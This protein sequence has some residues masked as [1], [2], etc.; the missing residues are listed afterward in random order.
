MPISLEAIDRYLKYKVSAPIAVKGR[1]IDWLLD[2]VKDYT[3]VDYDPKTVPYPH[4][5]E[6]L[7]FACATRRCLLFMRMRLGKT[8]ITLDWAELLRRS[9]QW[10]GKGLVLVPNPVLIYVWESEAKTHSDLKLVPVRSGYA[11]FRDACESDADLV[12]VSFPSLQAIL[13][14]RT[15]S[16]KGKKKLALSKEL[17]EEFMGRFSFVAVDEIHTCKNQTTLRWQMAE[18]LSRDSK[19]FIGL[20][21][22]PHGRDP[23]DLW[24]QAFLADRGRTLGRHY[25]FFR[26]AFG[27]EI[28][29]RFTRSG[30][31][32]VF[33]IGKLPLL[34]Q[35]LGAISLSYGTEAVGNMPTVSKNI[36]KLGLLPEQ[37]RR[38]R[39][40]IQKL[41]EL[42][43]SQTAEI[44]AIFVRLRQISSGYLPAVIE[45]T[46]EQQIFTFPSSKLEWI[47][48]LIENAEQDMSFVLY[49]DFIWTGQA[50]EKLLTKHK[51]RFASVHGGQRDKHSQIRMF[52]T[53]QVRW[54]VLNNSAGIGIDLSV[55]D[56]CCFVESPVS[57]TVR[58][59]VEARAVLPGR[60]TPLV[61]EDLLCSKVE[62]KILDY[63]REGK[64]LLSSTVFVKELMES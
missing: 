63:L 53:K 61:I 12:A 50:I 41:I 48:D 42:G 56:Y 39:D 22:T 5:L 24:A 55:A 11:A 49:H 18:A 59:Q 43:P 3:G 13:C 4:Q 51:K 34:K 9:G 36:V 27:K 23:F 45:E 7:V 25:H 64:E 40:A 6:A 15:E 35:K 60:P 17:T 58:A 33:D 47:E 30:K 16:E 62:E 37:R 54:M 46:K 32:V 28:A 10:Q 21:G 2:Q 29:N 52:Q 19:Y 8:K 20:T 57:P 44:G 31:E 38:Y 26:Y 14:E 1:Q